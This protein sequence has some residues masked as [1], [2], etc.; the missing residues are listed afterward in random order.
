M[1]RHGVTAGGSHPR[2]GPEQGSNRSWGGPSLGLLWMALALALPDSLV[3][4]TPAGAHPLPAQR[5]PAIF[6]RT[7]PQLQNIF[8]LWNLTCPACKGLFTAIDFGLQVSTKGAEVKLPKGSYRVGAGVPKSM[9]DG[10]VGIH[11]PLVNLIS[12][13]HTRGYMPPRSP[14]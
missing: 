9:P 11:K 2:S 4:W 12:F 13:R 5:H 8:G 14:V 10:E 3:L 7:V 6:S 1:S